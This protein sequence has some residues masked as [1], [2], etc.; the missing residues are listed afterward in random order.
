MQ[1][2]DKDHYTCTHCENVTRLATQ[3]A[4]AAGFAAEYVEMIR[5][6]GLLHDVGKISIPESV[7]TKPSR[8]TSAEYEIMKSHVERSIEIIRHLPSLNYVVPIVVGHHERWDGKGYPRG[9]A[10]TEIPRGARCVALADA[11]DAIV[12]RRV[13][14]AAVPLAEA[15]DE[16]ERGLG[17]QFDPE[18]GALFV[19]LL[20]SGELEGVVSDRDGS[21]AG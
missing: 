21:R 16:I 5:Q 2:S 7:L 11:F 10:G 3:L 4:R 8:L 9:L 20:R 1:N 12:S 15:I 14:K 6:A 19:R 13:Y 17:T 18:L